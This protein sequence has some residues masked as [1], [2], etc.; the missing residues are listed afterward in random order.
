MALSS[1]VRELL[2]P[3]IGVP[4]VMFILVFCGAGEDVREFCALFEALFAFDVLKSDINVPAA[5]GGARG[6]GAGIGACAASGC[7]VRANVLVGFL[8]I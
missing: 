8:G 3:C 6:V 2:A 4:P 5:E 7:E 1:S